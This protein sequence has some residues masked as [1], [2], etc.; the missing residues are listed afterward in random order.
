M[1]NITNKQK[2]RSAREKIHG[3]VKDNTEWIEVRGAVDIINVREGRRRAL[4]A[5]KASSKGTQPEEKNRKQSAT[6]PEK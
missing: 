3:R 4:F 2:K 1:I 6:L 5:R